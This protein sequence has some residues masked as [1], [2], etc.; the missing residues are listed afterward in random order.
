[1]SCYCM[2]V[3]LVQC[4]RCSGVQCHYET[5]DLSCDPSKTLIFICIT[6]FFLFCHE[7]ELAQRKRIGP[8]TQG[9][10]DR[11]YHSLQVFFLHRIFFVDTFLRLDA[12]SVGINLGLIHDSI[13]SICES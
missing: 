7:S 2:Y 8:I 11:N 12:L 13:L 1:M 10:V 5:L 4:G 6:C 9:S 3:K